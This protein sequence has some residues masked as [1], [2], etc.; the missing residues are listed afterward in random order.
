M[1]VLGGI[2]DAEAHD[3]FVQEW[4]RVQ[5]HFLRAMI[6]SGAEH[7][8]VTAGAQIVAL[9]Q[10]LVCASI[11]IGGDRLEQKPLIAIAGIKSNS[12]SRSGSAASGVEDVSG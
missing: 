9:K 4:R 8:F 3:D 6:I 10:W 12:D 7:Q 1:M 11:G 2:G 5:C